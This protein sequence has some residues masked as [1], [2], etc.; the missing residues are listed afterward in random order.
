LYNTFVRQ[1]QINE[2][3]GE[4]TLSI[5]FDP[6]KIAADRVKDKRDAICGFCERSGG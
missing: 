3:P 4:N 1:K 6:E 5:P 2:I